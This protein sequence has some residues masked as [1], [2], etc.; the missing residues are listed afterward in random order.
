VREQIKALA[1]DLLIQHGYR[2]M[3]FGDLAAALETTR[4]NIHYHFGHKQTLVEEVLTDYVRETTA[5]MKQIW[6]ESDAPLADKIARNVE[7]SRKRYAKYNSPRREG[8]NWSL[9]ARMRQDSSELTEAGHEALQQFGRDLGACITT[10]IEDA[11]R[12]GEFVPWMPVEDV[13][14][15]LIG[16]ANSAAPIT[17][18]AGTFE[19]LEQ[20]YMGFTRIITHAFGTEQ[21]AR[22][23]G[24]AKRPAR[25][26]RAG[27]AGRSPA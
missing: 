23:D 7:Y 11:K 21:A 14:L 25:Q 2:G 15:Q 20:L 18:D 13:A 9:I 26:S 16:I 8:R 1:L 6:A 5:A 17:Q 12:R 4:A 24:R 22:D 27:A 3:S 10:A 19:R